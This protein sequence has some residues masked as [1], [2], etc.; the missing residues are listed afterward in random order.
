[1]RHGPA[2]RAIPAPYALPVG[3][4][5]FLAVG[6]VAA[7]L[8]GRLPAT[9]VLIAC[10][11]V[12]GVMSF[13]AEPVAL[14]LLAGIAWLTTVGFSRPPYAQLRP[15]GPAAAHAAIVIGASALAGAALGL[16]FRWYW[17]RLTLVSM[18]TYTGMRASRADP[19]APKTRRATPVGQTAPEAKPGGRTANLA[20]AIGAIGG[21][22]LVAGVV[23]AAIA[24]PLL[25]AVLAAWR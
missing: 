9:G 11:A 3:F 16:V 1:M 20:R 13:A 17:R 25:T 5:M 12:A 24:L 2:Q 15:T 23:A 8:H 7:G 19:R 21:R 18:G 10:A 14:V 22:R 6:T 4:A